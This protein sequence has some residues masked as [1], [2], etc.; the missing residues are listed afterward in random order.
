T[1][2]TLVALLA[3]E[4]DRARTDIFLPLERISVH[5]F[6]SSDGLTVYGHLSLP[7]GPG[8]HPAVVVCTSGA[9]GALDKEGRYAQFSEHPPL[10]TAGFAVFTVDHRGAPGHGADFDACSEMGGKDI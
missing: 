2:N 4:L 1:L 9:G 6:A 10:T 8:P 7:A 3:E 5:E